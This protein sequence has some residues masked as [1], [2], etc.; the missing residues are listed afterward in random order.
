MGT[1]RL[2]VE[3]KQRDWNAVNNFLKRYNENG[4]DFLL[5]IVMG[6]AS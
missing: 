2:I 5:N 6:D 3:N 4:D 1:C